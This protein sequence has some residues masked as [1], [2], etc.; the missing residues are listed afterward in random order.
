VQKQHVTCDEGYCKTPYFLSFYWV[1]IHFKY[2]FDVKG[3]LDYLALL[4]SSYA[5]VMTYSHYAVY[6]MYRCAND[7]NNKCVILMTSLH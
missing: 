2:D 6:I 3:P 1:L 5:V 4:C 7:T